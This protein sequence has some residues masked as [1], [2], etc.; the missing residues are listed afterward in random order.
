MWPGV[1]LWS[2]V[3]RLVSICLIVVGLT[4]SHD[5]STFS[6]FFLTSPHR[7]LEWLYQL[8][9][10]ITSELKVPPLPGSSPPFLVSCFLDLS[11]FD[12]GKM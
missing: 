5:K 1:H 9:I 11:H 3:S 7:F 2:K 8:V 10:L 4:R 6:F 12:W